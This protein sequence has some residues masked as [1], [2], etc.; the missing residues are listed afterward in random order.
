MLIDMQCSI[1]QHAYI[2]S[3]FSFLKCKGEKYLELA[4][5]F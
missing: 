1:Q 4:F 3:N 5:I 2:Y